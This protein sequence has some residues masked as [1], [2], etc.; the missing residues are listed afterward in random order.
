MGPEAGQGEAERPNLG[1]SHFGGCREGH[2]GQGWLHRQQRPATLPIYSYPGGG[3][4]MRVKL[5]DLKHQDFG[6]HSLCG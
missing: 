3:R 1:K 6:D 2:G 5:L 4:V